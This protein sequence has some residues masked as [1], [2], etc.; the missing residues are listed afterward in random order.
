MDQQQQQNVN[1]AAEEWTDAV[2]QSFQTL[3]DQAVN[4]QESN[5]KLTQGFFQQFVEQL[6]SQ[7]Q[8]LQ[9]VT[10]S[11]QQQAFET[12]AQQSA[13]AYSDFLGSALSFYQQTMSQAAQVA[14][15]GI[16]TAEQV[17]E[18]A[19]QSGAQLAEQAA[20]VS[21]RASGRDVASSASWEVGRPVP[22]GG[23]TSWTDDGPAPSKHTPPDHEAAMQLI[24]ELLSEGSGYDEE[25]WPEIAEA[26][27][28][29][30]PSHRKL[31]VE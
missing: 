22:V 25:T 16:Q 21:G 11:L 28:R 10:Q 30:R 27:D 9:Q 14:E 8:G 29:D 3:A 15:G 23:P 5:L 24:D 17:A 7:T 1:Q 20:L 12:L 18:Q 26:L 2:R 4:L 13:K 19:M 6:Q 31:F